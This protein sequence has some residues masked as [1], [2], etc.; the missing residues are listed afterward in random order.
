[1]LYDI[2]LSDYYDFDNSGI[3][4][5][6]CIRKLASLITE[7]KDTDDICR[8]FAK[9]PCK[10]SPLEMENL[11]IAYQRR[12]YSEIKQSEKIIAETNGILIDHYEGVEDWLLL[13][14]DTRHSRTDQ[15]IRRDCLEMLNRTFD[16][17]SY[18]CL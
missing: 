9:V 1:M 12:A 11:K 4:T 2:S 17:S 14:S 8:Y 10:V 15:E 13:L 3:L 18:E 5:D 6:L 7:L 16:R